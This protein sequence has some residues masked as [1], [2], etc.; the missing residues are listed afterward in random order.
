MRPSCC[1]VDPSKPFPSVRIILLA[2]LTLLFSGW[3]NCTAIIS[4]NSCL[5]TVPQPIVIALEPDTISDDGESVP[6]IVDGSDFVPLSQIM[7]NGNP[8]QTAFTD[9]RHLQTTITKQTLESFGGSAGSTVQISV[10]SQERTVVVGCP[11]GLSSG[12]LVLFIN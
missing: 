12:T 2:F 7:W 10:R 11:I 1:L 6:L 3:S 5:S 9:S 8:L 4:F